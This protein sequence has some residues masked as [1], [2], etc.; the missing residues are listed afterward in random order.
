MLGV[1]QADRSDIQSR[2][3]HRRQYFGSNSRGRGDNFDALIRIDRHS[4]FNIKTHNNS[5]KTAILEAPDHAD[6]AAW[7]GIVDE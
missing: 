4:D 1:V 2:A 3:L 7:F 6:C 5:V